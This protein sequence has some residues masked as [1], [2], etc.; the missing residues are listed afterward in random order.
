VIYLA[1]QLVHR[2]LV[3]VMIQTLLASSSF[4]MLFIPALAACCQGEKIDEFWL[5]DTL[6]KLDYLAFFKDNEVIPFLYSSTFPVKFA[7]WWA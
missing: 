3:H 1:G 5:V 7:L 6:Y 2:Q 4:Y